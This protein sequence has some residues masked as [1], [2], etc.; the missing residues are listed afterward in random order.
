MNFCWIIAVAPERWS[1]VSA[2]V[3]IVKLL[4]HEWTTQDEEATSPEQHFADEAALM[5]GDTSF[6]DDDEDEVRGA[7]YG[8]G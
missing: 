1:E 6:D 5:A 4:L 8:R 3:K 2:V 7:I